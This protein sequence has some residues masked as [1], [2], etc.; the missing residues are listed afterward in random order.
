MFR[1]EVTQMEIHQVTQIKIQLPPRSYSQRLLQVIG[2]LR[3]KIVPA[4]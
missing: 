1:M 3:N 2:M 4:I